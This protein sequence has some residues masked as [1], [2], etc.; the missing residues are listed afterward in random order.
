LAKYLLSVH[1]N[2]LFKGNV[3]AFDGMGVLYTQKPLGKNSKEKI[4]VISKYKDKTQYQ[5][6]IQF[7]ASLSSNNITPAV[8]QLF[9]IMYRR[10]LTHLKLQQIGRNH[11]NMKRAVEIPKHNVKVLPVS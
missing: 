5:I 7:A 2:S 4:Q 10:A 6:N 9:N 8:I 11:Y 3:Y 1:D